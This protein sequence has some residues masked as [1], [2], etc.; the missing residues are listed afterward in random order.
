VIGGFEFDRAE[1]GPAQHARIGALAQH[2]LAQGIR[3]VRLVGHTDPVGT[4]GYNRELGQ[5]RAE[6]VRQALAAAL[7]RIRP[8]SAR[9]VAVTVESAGETRPL[10][11]GPEPGERARDRRVEVFLPP[12]PPP[13]AQRSPDTIERI[14]GVSS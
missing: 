14:G 1:L 7:E 11:R 12:A 10:S 9:G 8:G 2:L 13:P 3:S 6:A 5:R 4:P